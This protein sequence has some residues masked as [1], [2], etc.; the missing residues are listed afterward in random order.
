MP[1]DRSAAPGGPGRSGPGPGSPV[2]T[3]YSIHYTKLYETGGPSDPTALRVVGVVGAV[4][5]TDFDPT[6]VGPQF[7][8]AALQGNGRR[9]FVLAR[10]PSDPAALV[11][12][13]RNALGAIAPDLPMTI[14]PM[15]DSYNFV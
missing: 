11:P 9:F 4:N 6:N 14:R 10:T 15:Q 13:V 3:S 12:G 8:R 2:I 1:G 7:Y 5:H